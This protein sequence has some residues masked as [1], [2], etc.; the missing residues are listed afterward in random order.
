MVHWLVAYG[1]D[2]SVQNVFGQTP[3]HYAASRG[4]E[5]IVHV[6]CRQCTTVGATVLPAFK[7]Q[8]RPSL[9]P[10]PPSITPQDRAVISRPLPACLS[11]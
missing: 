3:L 5:Q 2:P 1:A 11:S 9:P 7:S 4:D 8:V 10:F 6:L